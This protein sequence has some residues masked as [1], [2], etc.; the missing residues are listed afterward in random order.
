M[1][2]TFPKTLRAP[3]LYGEYWFNGDPVLIR[4]SAGSVFLVDFWDYS[5]A[6]CLRTVPYL[7]DWSQKY[8]EYGLVIVGVHSPEFRFGRNFENVRRAVE[9]FRIKYSVVSDNEGRLWNLYSVRT[10][11]TKFLVDKDGFIRCICQGEGDYEQFERMI[12]FLIGESGIR[13]ELPDLTAPV[14]ETD[15]PGTVCYRATGEIR[16][17][18]LHGE[19]GNTEG[20][21]PE[22]TIEYQDQGLYLPGRFYVQGKWLNERELIR[23]EGGPGEEGQ[24]S[25]LYQASEVNAVMNGGKTADCRVFVR[26]DGAWI[27]EES[28]GRDILVGKDGATFVLIDRVKM[29]NLIKNVEF[30][31]HVLRLSTSSTGFE[32]YT[33][34]FST[35]PIPDVIPAN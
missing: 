29:F 5:S 18:Y 23:F 27:E 17:G 35:A 16:T 28:R 32:L 7:Q 3:E 4:E 19:I 10:R 1:I 21:N 2:E 14:H 9:D 8:S 30:G 26:Q 25:L 20:Y 11:P 12:Q 15:I 31:E 13:G 24:V 22:S 6:S 34:S 33:F